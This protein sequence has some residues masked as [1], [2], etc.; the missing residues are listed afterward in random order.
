MDGRL[1]TDVVRWK[2][3]DLRTNEVH[4]VEI[5]P[6]EMTGFAF[7]R[8]FGSWGRLA[9]GRMAGLMSSRDPA[10]FSFGG[11]VRT[12][13]HHDSLIDWQQR[14]GKVRVTDHL[15]R[16]F[17]IMI[18]SLDMTDRTLTAA[19]RWRFTYSFDCLLLRRIA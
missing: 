2:F 14:P 7:G 10:P 19:N 4:T 8:S 18:R 5:N 13:T 9:D 15:D 6:N 1:M 16:V 11:I 12:Q 17:E 3:Q